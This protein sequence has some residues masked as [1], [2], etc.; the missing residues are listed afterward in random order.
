MIV[1]VDP[2]SPIETSGT[3]RRYSP[4]VVL[5]FIGILLVAANMRAGLTTVGAVLPGIRASLDL[6]ATAAGILS[7]LPLFTFALAS[8]L[9]PPVAVRFGLERTLGGALAVLTC[10]LVLRSLPVVGAIWIGTLI[11]GSAI[12]FCNVLLPSLVKRDFP[13]KMA[14]VTS[15]YVATMSTVGAFASGV[16]IPIAGGAPDGWR[17]ALGCWAGLGLVALAVWLPQLKNRSLPDLAGGVLRRETPV[18]SPRSPW[19]SALGWQITLYMGLQS[20]AFYT[21]L[22]WFPSIVHDQGVS[23]SAAGWYL[24]VYQVVAVG[25][26]IATPMVMNRVRDLR[27]IGFFCSAPIFVGICGLMIAPSFSLLWLIGTGIGSGS[28]LVLALSL[29]VF[30]TR[31]HTQA[32]ALS[33]MA[34]SIGYLLAGA[35]PALVGILHDASGT[36]TLPLALLAAVAFLQ[37][38]FAVLSGRNRF[39]G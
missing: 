16:A 30:R 29:F 4:R 11:L 13:G 21:L 34:Q 10:G 8:P 28:S 27:A 36:W 24:F 18:R 2:P 37:A 1:R 33:G 14:S 6:S 17:M 38:I 26:V 23:A 20:M 25:A 32:A 3:S 31:D 19:R 12:A 15:A 7:A 39:I 5:L 9:A 22:S 35:G